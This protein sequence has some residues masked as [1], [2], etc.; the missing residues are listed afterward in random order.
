[1]DVYEPTRYVLECIADRV[2]PGGHIVIDDYGTVSGATEAIDEFLAK[3]PGRNL[4][5]CKGS[6]YK[7]PAYIVM[8]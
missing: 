8:D 1:M 4:T 7:V 3:R 5:L 2:V 6:Y